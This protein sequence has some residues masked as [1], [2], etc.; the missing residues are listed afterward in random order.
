MRKELNLTTYPTVFL[1]DPASKNVA[2][3]EGI[4]NAEAMIALITF[5]VTQN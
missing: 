3:Y 2:R 5:A 1:L 4:R